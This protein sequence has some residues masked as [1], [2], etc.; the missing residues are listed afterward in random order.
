MTTVSHLKFAV[1]QKWQNTFVILSQEIDFTITDY[2]KRGVFAS[3]KSLKPCRDPVVANPASGSTSSFY[4]TL[5]SFNIIYDPPQPCSN[6]SFLSDFAELQ[7]KKLK[8]GS[9]D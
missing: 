6:C 5:C 3:K 1:Y 9:L 7:T 4:T 8:S 2:L